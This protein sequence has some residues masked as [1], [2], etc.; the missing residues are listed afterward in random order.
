MCSLFRSISLQE[1]IQIAIELIFQNNPQLKVTKR[2]LKQFFNFVTS[3]TH[4][5]LNGSFYDQVDGISMESLL[6]PVLANLFMS[7]HK[8]KSLQEFDK[9][10]VLMHKRY[11]DDIFCMFGNEIDEEN[12]FE[13]LNCRH[14]N[15][16][17]TIEKG[18]NK[19]LSFL[20]ILVKNEGNRFLTSFHRKKTSIGL[21]T[22]F[23]SFTPMSYKIGLIRCLIH[24]AF[25]ISSSYIIFH[26]ELE[27]IKILLQKNM[28]PKSVIDNQIKTFLDKQFTVDSGTSSEKQKHYIIAY[29]ILD[30][31]LM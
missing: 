17:F 30:I 1:T 24:R 10:N 8:K 28:Y 12:V 15:I 25:K 20:E 3:G 31:F 18:S 9:G 19:F 29:H 4:F 5:I 27:K 21:F 6:G 22:Q 23:H 26:N 7:F 13:F 16:K 2:E 14:K 11:V